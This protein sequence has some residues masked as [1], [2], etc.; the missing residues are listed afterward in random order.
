MV[1]VLRHHERKLYRALAPPSIFGVYRKIVN[2]EIF[3]NQCPQFILLKVLVCPPSFH[4]QLPP[5]YVIIQIINNVN[6]Q[7]YL[8]LI[9][10][11]YRV[12][13]NSSH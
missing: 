5:M 3:D 6:L 12:E 4:T 8:G 9:Y 1:L 10:T 2:F 11:A 7:F 13:Q